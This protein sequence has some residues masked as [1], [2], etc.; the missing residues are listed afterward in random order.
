MLGREGNVPAEAG[1]VSAHWRGSRA[2]DAPGKEDIVDRGK[3]GGHLHPAGSWQPLPRA[4][5]FLLGEHN[6]TGNPSEAQ[7]PESQ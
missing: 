3:K 1:T 4:L 5:A 7:A 2:T 6:P